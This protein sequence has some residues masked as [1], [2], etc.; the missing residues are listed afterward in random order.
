MHNNSNLNGIHNTR[1]ENSKIKFENHLKYPQ[2]PTINS[3]TS[4]KYANNKK[5]T[6]KDEFNSN[7]KNNP[8]HNSYRCNILHLGSEKNTK[9]SNDIIS[10][11]YSIDSSAGFK[12]HSKNFFLKPLPKLNTSKIKSQTSNIA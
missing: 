6:S 12:I 2:K 5:S 1:S 8:Y 4:N 10:S 7:S 11:H 3:I 9:Y